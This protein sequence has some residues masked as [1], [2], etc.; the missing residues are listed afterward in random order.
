[1]EQNGN[2]TKFLRVF[3]FLPKKTVYS[4]DCSKWKESLDTWTLREV[5]PMEG[6]SFP[7]PFPDVAIENNG[8]GRSF[9]KTGVKARKGRPRISFHNQGNESLLS[10]LPWYVCCI[11]L[12]TDIVPFLLFPKCKILLQ[13]PLVCFSLQEDILGWQSNINFS[14]RLLDYKAFQTELPIRWPSPEIEIYIQQWKKILMSSY[15]N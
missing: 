1:M 2:L 7:I 13:L 10:Q 11:P 15:Y 4:L 12:P 6:E 9:K 8:W 14:C 3:H 5:P